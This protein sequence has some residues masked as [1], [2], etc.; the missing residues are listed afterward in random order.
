MN[1]NQ[2]ITNKALNFFNIYDM[3]LSA[4]LR[5]PLQSGKTPPPPIMECSGYDTKLHLIV[6]FQ[7]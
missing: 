5:I 2:T 7:F 6:R 3:E 4:E 1:I